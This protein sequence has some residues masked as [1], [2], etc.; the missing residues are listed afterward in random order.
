[1]SRR[2][3]PCLDLYLDKVHIF[4]IKLLCFYFELLGDD[5]NVSLKIQC[6]RIYDKETASVLE[7]EQCN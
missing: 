6:H 3:I 2:R 4:S 7:K 5:T 1:M